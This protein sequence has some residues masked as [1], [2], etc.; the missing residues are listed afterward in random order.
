MFLLWLGDVP[1]RRLH[2]S[3]CRPCVCPE[4]RKVR[5]VFVF[6][7][8]SAIAVRDPN[9]NFGESLTLVPAAFFLQA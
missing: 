9:V 4:N 5:E 1:R 6:V 7:E 3:I 2:R 8:H